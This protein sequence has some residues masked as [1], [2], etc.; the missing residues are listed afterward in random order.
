[1]LNEDRSPIH[2][3]L[4]RLLGPVVSSQGLELYDVEMLTVR[5]RSV[6][7]VTVERPGGRERGEGVSVAELAETSREMSAVLDV[8]DPLPSTY[9]LEVQS[10]GVERKLARRAHFE[11]STGE[12]V[13]V[14]CSEPVE[15][16]DGVEGVLRSVTDEGAHVEVSE[17]ETVCVPWW[18]ITSAK[19]VFDWSS[20]GL[21]KKKKK[22]KR[23]RR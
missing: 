13:H 9:A 19:T 2:E 17:G 3:E 11:R 7:R 20:S 10:P 23:K 21:G 22:K 5:G 15:T 6:L 18:V 8:E 14:V 12:R 1:M 16:R 4:E